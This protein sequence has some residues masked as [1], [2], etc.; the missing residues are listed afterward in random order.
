MKRVLFFAAVL[1]LTAWASQHSAAQTFSGGTG[2]SGDPYQISSAADLEQLATDVNGGNATYNAVYFKLTADLDLELAGYG[3]T[4]NSGKG[5]IPIGQTYAFCGN[6]DGDGHVISNLYIND[7]TLSSAGLFGFIDGATVHDLGL[8]NV[9][10]TGGRYVGGVAGWLTGSSS[11]S[12]CY[13]TGDVSGT[14]NVVGGVAG[15]VYIS[16]LSNCYAT[17]TVSGTGNET[18]GVAGG[19]T[20]GS[21]SNCYATG[22]VSGNISVGGVVGWVG[23]NASGSS[24]SNCYATGDVSGNSNVGGVVGWVGSN[25]SSSVTDC[26]A[27]NPSVTGNSDVGRVAGLNPHCSFSLHFC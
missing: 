18:G 15:W 9:N 5:W 4:F 25:A 8:E 11:L 7:V 16:S 17:G 22:T 13:A 6:F 27:L 10:I 2:T 24:V 1:C 19:V 3:T 14:G 12:N 26:A 20:N 23:G 21:L